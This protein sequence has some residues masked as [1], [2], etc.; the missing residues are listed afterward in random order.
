VRPRNALTAFVSAGLV[1]LLT[2]VPQLGF[3]PSDRLRQLKAR[4]EG[5]S[6]G[7]AEW[8]EGLP[9]SVQRDFAILDADGG[10]GWDLVQRLAAAEPRGRPTC[11][12]ARAHRFLKGVR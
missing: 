3:G 1:I 4:L 12:A 9:E 11:E 2:A 6:G 5:G 10:A 8:R 7:L